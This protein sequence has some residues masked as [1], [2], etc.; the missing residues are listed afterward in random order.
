MTGELRQL[1]AECGLTPDC[2]DG[3]ARIWLRRRGSS[4]PTVEWFWVAAASGPVAKDGPG[5][6]G[7]WS[8]LISSPSTLPA[9]RATAPKPALQQF[10]DIDA[11]AREFLDIITTTLSL[12]EI[13]EEEILIAQHRHSEEPPIRNDTGKITSRPGRLWR[14]FRLLQPTHAMT[15]RAEFVYRSHCKQ[16][17]DQIERA[18]LRWMQR[19]AWPAY[20]RFSWSG[21]RCQDDR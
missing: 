4:L 11:A 20:R 5:F 3:I 16:I 17:L 14:S 9:A 6:N 8:A 18:E 13:A 1:A 7:A 15:G 12:T 10:L 21:A 19:C 2:G